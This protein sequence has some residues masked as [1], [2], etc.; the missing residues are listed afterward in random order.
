MPLRPCHPTAGAGDH[1]VGDQGRIVGTVAA[2]I[3]AAL[4]LPAGAL[5]DRWNLDR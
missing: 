2:V 1:R 3:R 4:R 5:A